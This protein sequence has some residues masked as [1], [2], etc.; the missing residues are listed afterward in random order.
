MVKK[1]SRGL[2]NNNPLNIRINGDRFQGEILPSQD[3]AFKQF[4]TMSHGYRAGFKTLYTYRHKHGL[5]TIRQLISR[6]APENENDTAA[7]VNR[8]ATAAR[9]SPD[10]RIDVLSKEDMVPIVAAMSGVE[11]GIP[12]VMD[13]VE[14]GWKLFVA[15]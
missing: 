10:E 5:K 11:N 14:A 9:K 3:K 1:L 2:R 13:D 4:E 12:A 6:W 8:V 15:K 7:Y